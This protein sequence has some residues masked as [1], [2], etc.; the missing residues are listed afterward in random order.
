MK[1]PI[2]RG[3]TAVRLM[4]ELVALGCFF[5]QVTTGRGQKGVP[6]I[7]TPADLHFLDVN[8][9]FDTTTHS[10]WTVKAP[11]PTARAGFAIAAG[12]IPRA[13][14]GFMLWVEQS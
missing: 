10:D 1:P 8:T 7:T 9:A 4:F 2:D 12:T 3:W 11:M 6:V 13:L 14:R 5:A